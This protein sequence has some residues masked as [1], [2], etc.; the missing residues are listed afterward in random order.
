MTPS[1]TQSRR[2]FLRGAAGA[3]LAV[4][5]LGA[6]EAS[7]QLSGPPRPPL[8][9]LPDGL[10]TLGVAS[11]DPLHHAVVLWTR[12][13]P[14]PLAGGGMPAVDVPVRWEV[15]HDDGFRRVVRRGTAVAS[16]AFGHA[17]HVDVRGLRPGRWYH[18][19][20]RVGDEVSP[21]GRTRTAPPPG[22]DEGLRFVF[23]S[24]QNWRDGFWPAWLQVPA[25]EPDLVVHLGDYI[26]E[27]GQGP[28]VRD[29]N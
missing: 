28:G 11:G 13:A 15:A 22:S 5:L 29:H 4:P 8:P 19:R 7:R 16:P 9:D 24:C 12:L 2:T 25:D 27:G 26:Y 14:V 21:V 23:A 20:F 1:P 10:F 17:V 18:Y 6:G 3:A